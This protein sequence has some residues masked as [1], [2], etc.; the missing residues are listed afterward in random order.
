MY[1]LTFLVL[2]DSGSAL[3][4]IKRKYV[5]PELFKNIDNSGTHCFEINKSK[6]Y[7]GY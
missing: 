3:F 5:N 2:L 4:L 7:L 1:N 6:V